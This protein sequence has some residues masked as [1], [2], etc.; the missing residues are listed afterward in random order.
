MLFYV[1]TGNISTTQ[2]AQNH[3]EAALA[4]LKKQKEFG[5]FTIVS[6]KEIIEENSSVHMFFC[7]KTLLEECDK[8]MKIVN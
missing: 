5:R 1:Q 2:I 8:Q 3:K 6:L 7:T 4:F